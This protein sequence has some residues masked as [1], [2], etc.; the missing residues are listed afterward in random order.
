[1]SRSSFLFRGVFYAAVA[2]YPFLVY[3]GLKYVPPGTLGLILAI[4]LAF[5]FGIL[6]PE[7]KPVLL[8]MMV[9]LIAFALLASVLGST[10][11]LLVYPV[12]VNLFL[13]ITFARSLRGGDSVL[14][15]MVKARK[16][17][18][19]E[20]VPPYLYRLT[21]VWVFFFVL[22]GVVAAWTC[23]QSMEVWAIYNGLI[24]YI[25][26]GCLFAGEFVFRIFYRRKRG[27]VRT[28][29]PNT[30]EDDGTPVP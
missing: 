22:N 27:I 24:S 15:M 4:F 10:K 17:E 7:E 1:M 12:L 14:L 28:G 8:P 6:S 13:A 26:A 30:D 3:F 25:A 2:L 19:G 29:S 23:T 5:R 20:Y 11:M 18:I 16:V 21:Q 9:F